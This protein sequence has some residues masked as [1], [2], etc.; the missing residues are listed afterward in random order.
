MNIFDSAL[1][2]YQYYSNT[3]NGNRE[4]YNIIT[5]VNL[6]LKEHFPFNTINCI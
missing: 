1:K 3:N 5:T 2:Q 6:I 4:K